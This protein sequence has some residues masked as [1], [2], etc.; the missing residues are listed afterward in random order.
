MANKRISDL[1]VV[2]SATAGDVLPIDGTTTRKITIE[3]L[4]TDNLVAIK[5][6]T[7]AADKG[8][9]FTGLGTAATYDLTAAGKALLDDADATAQRATLGVVIGT[10]VQAYDAD[11]AALAAN[12]GTGIWCITGSGTG[13]VRTL[14]APAA[15]ITVTNGGGVAGNPTLG[16][17]NDLAALEGLA[18]TGFATRTAADTWA[19]RTLT[20]PAAGLTITN[21]AGVAGDPTFALANDLAALEALSGT[22]T[23]YYRSG[24]DTWS[25]VAI[26]SNI[27][28]T[29]GTLSASGGAGSSA[30][31]PQGRATLTSGVAVTTS[32]VTG[33]TNVYFTPSGGNQVPIYNGTSFVSTTFAELTLALDSTAAHAGYQQSGFNFD[34]FVINDAGTVRL[35]TGPSWAAGAVAGSDT[36]RGTGAGSTELQL[37]NGFWTNKNTITIRFGSA[38]GNTVSVAANQATYVGTIRTTADGVTEDSLLKRFV[39]NAYNQSR[40]QLLRQEPTASWTWSTASYHQANASSANQIAYVAG[41][42]GAEL[43]ATVVTV[44]L[45]STSTPRIVYAGIGL[46]STTVNSRTISNFNRLG[47]ATLSSPGGPTAHYTGY[48]QLGYHY[49]AWLEKGNGTDVQTWFGVSGSDY[50]TGI[51]GSTTA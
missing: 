13:S 10:D 26:G 42:T 6:L 44:V 2:T 25:P 46:D 17:A 49:I 22:N 33:A 14:T 37:L 3:N 4:L 12:A 38:S 34:L 31:A 50:Q 45:N 51:F 32:D 15:G 11:L 47:D 48:A 35:G 43:S 23:I 16:L 36:A 21:P 9:Q 41:L 19:Q 7:S 29:G 27:T 1:P 40:R 20:A 8:I 30:P 5:D 39:Y 28:F 18:S 24:V